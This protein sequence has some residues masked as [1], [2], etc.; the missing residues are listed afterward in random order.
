[1][2]INT[3]T[4]HDNRPDPDKLQAR[5]KREKLGDQPAFIGVE[6]RKT[7]RSWGKNTEYGERMVFVKNPSAHISCTSEYFTFRQGQSGQI[8]KGETI[9][10]TFV[11][12]QPYAPNKQS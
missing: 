12:E 5:L 11:I 3:L 9:G 2:D 4:V 7:S 6:L 8:I 1:M 10:A